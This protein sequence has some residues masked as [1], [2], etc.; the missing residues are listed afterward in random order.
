MARDGMPTA[1]SRRG[2]VRVGNSPPGPR[3]SYN[4]AVL[5][6]AAEVSGS[7]P[8]EIGFVYDTNPMDFGVYKAAFNSAAAGDTYSVVESFTLEIAFFDFLREVRD[9]CRRVAST[10]RVIAADEKNY[11]IA[12]PD[13][14]VMIYHTSSR[15]PDKVS[16]SHYGVHFHGYESALAV[17]EEIRARYGGKR[18]AEVT[19][20]YG[21]KERPRQ[22]NIILDPPKQTH[23]EFYPW[24]AGGIDAYFDRFMAADATLLFMSGPPGTGKTSLIRHI[25]YGRALPATLTYEEHFLA[26]DGMFVDFMLGDGDGILLIE[27]A[28]TMLGSRESEGNKLISRFLNVSDGLIKFRG[29]KIIFTTNLTDFRNVDPALTR[30]GRCY[31]VIKFREL[32]EDEAVRA[33]AVAGLQCPVGPRTLAEL[34]NPGGGGEQQRRIGF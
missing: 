11:V 23:D 20:W 19:W 7:V 5:S 8:P 30:P 3:R 15:A 2:P 16:R 24:I 10:S 14:L 27:D 26:A 32:T 1:G 6:A 29:K 17:W 22:A 9:I 21:E 4:G 34:F 28:D 12:W 33:A 18:L 25:L 31:D 13:G